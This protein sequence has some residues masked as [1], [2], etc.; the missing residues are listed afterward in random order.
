MRSHNPNKLL[1]TLLLLMVIVAGVAAG[2][3]KLSLSTQ[4][5]NVDFTTATFTRPLRIVG[6]LPGS[7]TT[8]DLVLLSSAAANNRIYLC[9]STNSWTAQGGGLP[10]GGDYG[11]LLVT[12]AMGVTWLSL[13]GDVSGIPS[14]ATVSK[15]QNRALAASAPSD[16][17]A[18]VWNAVDNRWQPGGLSAGVSASHCTPVDA[19]GAFEVPMGCAALLAGTVYTLASNAVV[20]ELTGTGT[21]WFELSAAGVF[22][23]R[24]NLLTATCNSACVAQSGAAGFSEDGRPLAS[25]QV[26]SGVLGTLASYEHVPMTQPIEAGDNVTIQNI[27][28]RQRITASRLIAT[29]STEPAA[30]GCD[31]GS[32]VGLLYARSGDPATVPTQLSRCVQTGATTYGWQPAGHGTGTTPPAAC[33]VGDLFFVPVADADRHWLG[34]TAANT[35]APLVGTATGPSKPACDVSQRGRFWHTPGDTGVADTLEWCRKDDT[36]AYAWH[37]VN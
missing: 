1:V 25:A 36:D 27:D 16:G 13:G 32:E 34:C 33:A 7:C 14:A 28:G 21:I 15:I 12:D 24:H 29:G 31:E 5:R 10:T 37:V 4:S 9:T 22:T 8:G 30:T 6:S 2:Q 3:T 35:W 11:Q 23:A 17:Q 19:A 20:N 18:L 26:S